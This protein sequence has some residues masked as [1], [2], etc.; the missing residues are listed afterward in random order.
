MN[1][2][3]FNFLSWIN[4]W[5]GSWGWAMVIFT[6]LIRLV[7]S[8]LDLKSRAG[9]RKTTQIQPKLAELQKK[10]ANDRDKLNQKTAELYKK[11]GVNPMSSCL[12]LL[13][14]WPILIIVF[15]AMRTAANREILG[16]VTEILN[17]QAP[18]MEPFLW[19][20]NLWM[21]DSL[22][23]PAWPDLGTLRQIPSNLWQEWFN[24]FQ[25]NLPV[26]LQGLDLTAA[27]FE[28]SSLMATLTQ[29]QAAM[30]SGNA[31]YTEA[32]SAS[33][34]WTFNLFVTTLTVVKEYNGYM[35]L[36]ILSAVTQVIMTKITG[37]QQGQNQPA[38]NDQAAATNKMMTWFF[39]IFSLVICFGYSS[40]FALYWV[41]GNLVMMAQT[42]IINKILDNRES[43]AKLAGEGTVK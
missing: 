26:L 38:A 37:A 14:T 11:E 12:P 34:G 6:V 20:K 32:I 28:S 22:F 31:A 18:T 40:A 23:S 13:L 27:S 15:S 24:G 9:M 39:P 35:I 10:Y 33:G 43:K 41:M 17:N 4:S 3:L 21:P 42:V 19:I 29:I 1:E 2:A 5:V 7:L 25:G 8:P 30:A 36:P 16:Q